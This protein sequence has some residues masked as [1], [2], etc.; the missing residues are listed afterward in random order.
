MCLFDVLHYIKNCDWRIRGP[1]LR[2]GIVNSIRKSVDG[3]YYG[4]RR[5]EDGKVV[6]SYIRGSEGS[7]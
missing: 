2:S 5:R 3:F 1:W 7:I 4:L 6:I